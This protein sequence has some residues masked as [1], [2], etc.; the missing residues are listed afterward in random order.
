MKT[1]IDND[2]TLEYNKKHKGVADTRLARHNDENNRYLCE[3]LAVIF[4][5]QGS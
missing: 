4:Y 3:G 1:S 2:I 5:R